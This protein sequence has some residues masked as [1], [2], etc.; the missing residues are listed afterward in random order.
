MT[1]HDIFYFR[2]YQEL[3][4]NNE[5]QGLYC[6]SIKDHGLLYA[7]IQG[8]EDE[9]FLYCL[10]CDFKLIPGIVTIDL[11]KSIVKERIENE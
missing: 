10:E 11:I 5:A 7:N 1:V 8:D 3:A 6:N 9:L 2:E 4:K